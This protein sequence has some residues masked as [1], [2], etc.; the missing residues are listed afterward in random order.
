MRRRVR[1]G[2]HET[3]CAVHPAMSRQ[4]RPRN[5]R[6]RSRPRKNNR[7]VSRVLPDGLSTRLGCHHYLLAKLALE[8]SALILLFYQRSHVS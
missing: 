5:K 6:K 3:I 2:A 8:L 1:D 4:T 7:F